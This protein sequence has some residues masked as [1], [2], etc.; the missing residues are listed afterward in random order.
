MAGL[1]RSFYSNL[2]FIFGKDESIKNV[3]KTSTSSNS[4]LTLRFATFHMLIFILTSTSTFALT[5]GLSN[6][7]TNIELQKVTR[8]T[9][10]F[11]IKNQKYGKLEASIALYK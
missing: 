8:L 2:F 5:L 1:Y 7:Y 3:L 9:L 4:S 11:F 6:I 10:K